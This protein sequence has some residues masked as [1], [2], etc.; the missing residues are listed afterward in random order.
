M[1][2]PM[3]NQ[4][5]SQEV[6]DALNAPPEPRPLTPNRLIL[7]KNAQQPTVQSTSTKPFQ[8]ENLNH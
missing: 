4:L 1:E 8:W 5:V 7:I 2:T 3:D 6:L